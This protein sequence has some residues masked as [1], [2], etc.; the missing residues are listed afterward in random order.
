MK[1][2]RSLD[3]AVIGTGAI[4]GTVATFLA[5]AGYEVEVVTKYP[6]VAQR[7][8]DQGFEVIGVLGRHVAKMKAVARISDL[9]SPK[10]IVFMA[11]KAT[12]LSEAAREVLP[13]LKEDSLVVSMQNG[14]C[15][16]ELASIVGKERTVG[17]VVGFGAT[18]LGP[19]KVEVTSGGHFWVGWLDRS[20]DHRLE[21]I[22][23]LL[24]IVVPVRLTEDFIAQEYSKLIVNSAITSMGAITGERLGVMLGRRE[25]REVFLG[26][27]KEAIEVANAMGLKVPPYEGKL[28]YYRLA[29]AKNSTLGRIWAHLLLRI[30]GFKYRRLKSSSLQSLQRGKKTEVRYLNGFIVEQGK[31]FGVPTPI[32]SLIVN[33]ITEIEEGKREISPENL[34]EFRALI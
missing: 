31:R 3:I 23:E 24:S 27:I 26:I 1:D 8:Q 33:L 11:M 28:D 32:N 22:G 4:G 2:P 34:R 15:E 9:S 21:V 5:E 19:A 29:R 6:E 10:D 7:V 30:I 25:V 16:Y 13:F 17:C 18:L 14:I 12:D 20:P